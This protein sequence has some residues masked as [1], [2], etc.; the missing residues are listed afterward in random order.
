MVSFSSDRS[1]SN[2]I[3]G[4]VKTIFS[5]DTSVQTVVSVTNNSVRAVDL[6]EGM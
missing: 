3:L 5:D 2:Y 6:S 4:N 1:Y